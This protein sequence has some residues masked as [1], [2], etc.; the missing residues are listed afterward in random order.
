MLHIFIYIG[1]KNR[2]AIC[3]GYT[4]FLSAMRIGCLVRSVCGLYLL[5]VINIIERYRSKFNTNI[6]DIIFKFLTA[7]S[8]FHSLKLTYLEKDRL[9]V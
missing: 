3:D 8:V 2:L 9:Q 4:I 7:I 5:E 6:L 1:A